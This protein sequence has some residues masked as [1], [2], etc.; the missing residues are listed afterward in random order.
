MP[1]TLCMH[2]PPAP[3]PPGMLHLT[4]RLKAEVDEAQRSSE[5][6]QGTVLHL[7]QQLKEVGDRPGGG[8]TRTRAPRCT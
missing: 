5:K 3:P 1:L 2:A 8:V 4:E 7:K 6:Y